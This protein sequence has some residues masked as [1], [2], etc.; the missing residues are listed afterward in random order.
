MRRTYPDY[1]LYLAVTDIVFNSLFEEPI[2]QLM[3][4]VDVITMNGLKPRLR[5]RVLSEVIYL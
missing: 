2:G 5:D 1:I 3:I 4:E